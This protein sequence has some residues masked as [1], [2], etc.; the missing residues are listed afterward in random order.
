MVHE[1]A[2]EDRGGEDGGHQPAQQ[3]H[4]AHQATE[5]LAVPIRN[6]D[7]GDEDGEAGGAGDKDAED[8][9]EDE[10]VDPFRLRQELLAGPGAP[11]GGTEGLGEGRGGEGA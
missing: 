2:V 5:D 8:E 11:D 6:E 9:E 4:A 10:E 7:L 1:H 3:E